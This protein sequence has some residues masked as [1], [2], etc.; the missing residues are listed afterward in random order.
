MAG[1]GAPGLAPDYAPGRAFP[2]ATSLHHGKLWGVMGTERTVIG[3]DIGGTKIGAALLRGRLPRAASGTPA[4]RETPEIIDRF[5]VLTDISSMRACLDGI[6]ACIA[7]L[8]HG[9]GRVEGIGVGV[10]SMVD[11]AAGHVV[12]STNLP[13]SDVPLRELLQ[14]RFGAPVVIDND[15]TAA[16]IGEHA[17]GAGAGAREMLMLTLGTGVGGGI[18]CGGRPYRGFSG[19]AA[20][21]GHIII[22]VNGRKCPANCPNHGCLEAYVAG[23]AMTAAAVAA[24][25]AEPASALG[26]A[27]AAGEAVDARLLTRIGL[28]GDAGAVAVLARLGEY[29]GAGL[30]TLVNIFNPEVIVIGGGAAAGGELLLGPARGVLQA[31][32]SR[33][34]RDQ[35]RVVPA[36]LGPDAGLIGAAAL[37][38]SELFPDDAHPSS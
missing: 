23:P 31:R 26:R 19:A 24:A 33:P 2:L 4:A 15:A 13:L 38:L 10:A 9:S 29:L 8:E 35:V 6:V 21:L 28:E 22:D 18:I 11:F 27:L 1:I 12:E 16:A 34:A 7:D 32:G 20:E 37:A 30:V 5:T 3:V 17:F 25:A 36:A 14:Q